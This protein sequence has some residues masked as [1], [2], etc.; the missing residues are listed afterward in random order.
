MK[1][2]IRISV[3]VIFLIN[4]SVALSLD[5]AETAF[6]YTDLGRHCYGNY[7]YNY[8]MDNPLI[9]YKHVSSLYVQHSKA[10]PYYPTGIEMGW[11]W[12]HSD[13]GPRFF[14]VKVINGSYSEYPLA[15]ATRGE[16]YSYTIKRYLPDTV[17]A[18]SIDGSTKKEIDIPDCP[19]GYAQAASERQTLNETNYSH[20]W[21]MKKMDVN[22]SWFAWS[23]LAADPNSCNDP[24][25]HISKNTDQDFAMVHD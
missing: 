7:G 12:K 18:F 10:D 16:N 15:W 20:F 1:Q 9:E 13:S 17:W 24:Y 8:V 5:W 14:V 23:N 3:A 22:S 19:F 21:A 11:W 4:C 6:D 2:I 25:Y